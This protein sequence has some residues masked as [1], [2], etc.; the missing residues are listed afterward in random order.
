MQMTFKVLLQFTIQNYV[1]VKLT[2]CF[3]L[4]FKSELKSA[5]IYCYKKLASGNLE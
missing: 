1:H 3:I 5:E 4:Y 2:Q